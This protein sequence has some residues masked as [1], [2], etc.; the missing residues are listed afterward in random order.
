MPPIP[1]IPFALMNMF[2]CESDRER[3]GRA[4]LYDNNRKRV[5][6]VEC[7]VS[8]TTRNTFVLANTLIN[9]VWY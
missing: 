5:C 2:V 6:A 4:S 9:G 1:L 8:I 7:A 3:E